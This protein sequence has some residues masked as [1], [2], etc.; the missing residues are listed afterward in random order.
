MDYKP[1]EGSATEKLLKVITSDF[2]WS[3]DLVTA[4]GLNEHARVSSALAAPLLHGIIEKRTID[5]RAYYRVYDPDRLDSNDDI[6]DFNI[7][8]KWTNAKDTKFVKT[9]PSSIFDVKYFNFIPTA[10][11]KSRSRSYK[12]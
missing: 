9:G 3:A 7:V 11:K 5:R 10:N 6:E 8:R 2:K 12:M 4:A 1:K